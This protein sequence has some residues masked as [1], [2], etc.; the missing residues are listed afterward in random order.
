MINEG[1]S[2]IERLGEKIEHPGSYRLQQKRYRQARGQS[3]TYYPAAAD[4]SL[5]TWRLVV[6]VWVWEECKK[7]LAYPIRLILSRALKPKH[8]QISLKDPAG[9]GL[10]LGGLPL[11]HQFLGESARVF[12]Y[13]CGCTKLQWPSVADDGSI[14]RHKKYAVARMAR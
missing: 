7:Q 12:C 2:L 13:K 5:E 14:L 10:G 11:P 1:M 6:R 8:Y 4:Y 3:Q 9:I